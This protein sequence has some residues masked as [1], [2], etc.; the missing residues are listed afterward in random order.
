[1]IM[2]FKIKKLIPLSAFIILLGSCK[3]VDFGDINQNPNQTTEPITSALL[4][5]VIGGVNAGL[6]DMGFNI[7]NQ[8]GSRTIAG[9]YAQ[10]YSQTQYTENSRY[11]RPTANMDAFYNNQLYDLQNI[12]NYNTDPE[13]KDKATLFGSNNNQIAVARILKVYFF[14]TITDMWG[15]IPYSQA[16]KGNGNIPYDKQ[17]NIYPDLLKELK[18]A[19][20]QFD[21]GSPAK[22]DI[23]LN[24]NIS[25]WKKFANSLRMLIALQMSKA[26]PTLGKSEFVAALADPAG[27]IQT[28]TDNVTMVYPGGAFQNPFYNYYFVVKRDDEAVSKTLTDWLSNHSDRR[29]NAYGTSTVGFPYGL[30]RDNAVA[31]GNSN[32]TFARPITQS[33]RDETDPVVVLGAAQVLLAR[34]EAAFLG[35]TGENY[36]NLYRAGIEQSWMEWSIYD[37]VQFTSYLT[38]TDVDLTTGDVYK[39]I[40]TQEWLAA[41]PSGV[42]GW[43][44]WRRTGYPVLTPAPGTTAIPR[45]FPHGQNEPQL[46]PNNYA[47]VAALY[48]VN[49]EADSQY[50]RM[51]WDK[52]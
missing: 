20:A 29:V 4:A 9:Y 35:W 42:R 46:N 30:T 40:A 44:I 47:V 7:W 18:E 2:K 13:T 23:L 50:A 19:V 34:A 27:S 6:G 26:N 1:M 25:K 39:K 15:D 16:L 5:N 48:T 52:P 8:G 10:Y 31:F 12:I 21:N 14:W 32:P 51:W 45:R 38:N 17:E 28:N 49:G 37:I 43:S 24:G 36:S 33:L 41:Y 11:T 22:G 3:K